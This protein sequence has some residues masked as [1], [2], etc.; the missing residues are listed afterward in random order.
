MA[1]ETAHLSSATRAKASTS[2]TSTK[3]SFGKIVSKHGHRVIE[4]AAR[5]DF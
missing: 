4:I 2:R 3:Q 1:L 5:F